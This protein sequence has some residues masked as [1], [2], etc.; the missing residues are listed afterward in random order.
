VSEFQSCLNAK[1]YL[2]FIG[3]VKPFQHAHTALLRNFASDPGTM[4]ETGLLE[5]LTGKVRAAVALNQ[6]GA[7]NPK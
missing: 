7:V 2:V 4:F 3:A 5:H 1:A 6:D